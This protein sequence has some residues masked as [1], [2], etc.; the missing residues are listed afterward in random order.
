MLNSHHGVATKK[1][2]DV[3]RATYSMHGEILFLPIL[4]LSIKYKTAWFH[5]LGLNPIKRLP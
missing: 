1:E 4:V 2:I 3:L 5:E